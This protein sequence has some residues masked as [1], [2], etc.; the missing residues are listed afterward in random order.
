MSSARWITRRS[1][2]KP[3]RTSPSFTQSAVKR[4]T[5]NAHEAALAVVFESGL[6][7]FS[8]G[9]TVY[10]ALPDDWKTYLSQVPTVWD[11]T[12]LLSGK[13]GQD[14]AIARRFGTRWYVAGIN[15]EDKTKTL[16]FSLSALK[17]LPDK[18]TLLYDDGKGGFASAPWQKIKTAVLTL[19]PYG[20][21]VLIFK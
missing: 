10:P 9:P 2:R 19:E 14:V 20:G 21:F 8:D 4:L 18:A 16:S 3:G 15:G 13:P 7:H 17:G 1:T 11:E 6:Q 12:K 5:T